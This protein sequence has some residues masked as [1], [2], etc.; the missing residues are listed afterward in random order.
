MTSYYLFLY[1]I[2]KINFINMTIE[3]LKFLTLTLILYFLYLYTITDDN[4][5]NWLEFNFKGVSENQ[6]WYYESYTEKIFTFQ[7]ITRLFVRDKNFLLSFIIILHFIFILIYIYIAL[8]YKYYRIF[9]CSY[10][11]VVL[12]VVPSITEVFGHIH[13]DYWMMSFFYVFMSL[14]YFIATFFYKIIEQS[15]KTFFPLIL[16]IILIYELNGSSLVDKNKYNQLFYSK[17]LGQ[18]VPSDYL[19]YYNFVLK[20]KDTVVFEEY[21][22]IFSL[23][24]KKSQSGHFDSVIHALGNDNIDLY[25][26]ELEKFKPTYIT[27]TNP[28][29]SSWQGWSV[30]QNYFFYKYILEHYEIKKTF[31]NLIVY[32]RIKKR[33]LLNKKFTCQI[34]N[35]SINITGLNKYSSSLLEVELNYKVKKKS[36]LLIQSFLSN[37]FPNVSLNTTLGVHSSHIPILSNNVNRFNIRILPNNNKIDIL[38]CNATLIIKNIYKENSILF[39][40]NYSSNNTTDANWIKGFSKTEPTFFVKDNVLNSIYEIGQI[41]GFKNGKELKIVDI[42]RNN[43]YITIKLSGKEILDGNLV[44]HPN[45]IKIVKDINEKR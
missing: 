1:L 38:D 10:Y 29:F 36:I 34:I 20:E 2:R 33:K 7:D 32:K 40:K 25:L 28:N 17:D 21:S 18:Y 23:L 26:K 4:I 37:I 16:F 31:A 41:L 3:I 9:R 22:T 39:V 5:L 8:K 35:N 6:F 45:K 19:D 13:D 14:F 12:F 24:S 43:G 42:L 30:G 27:T 15:N 44:G 11:G